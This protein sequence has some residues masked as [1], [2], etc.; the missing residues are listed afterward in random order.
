MRNSEY[1]CLGYR[2]EKSGLSVW[3]ARI[4]CG[5]KRL[6]IHSLAGATRVAHAF[7]QVLDVL[8]RRFAR[9]GHYKGHGK[10]DH[11]PYSTEGQG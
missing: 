4:D 6:V 8:R 10:V 7:H 1:E 11:C 9:A 2:G 5:F 3:K